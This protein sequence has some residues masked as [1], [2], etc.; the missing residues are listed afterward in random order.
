[1]RTGRL[2]RQITLQ[3]VSVVQ[4]DLGQPIETWTN[5]A[6]VWAERESQSAT[7]RFAAQQ[8]FAEVDIVWRIRWYPWAPDVRPDT[9]RVVYQGRPFNVLGAVELGRKEG[10]H[11]ATKARAE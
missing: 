11:I 6:T 5:V 4:D 9:H 10:L 3:S 1:V 8:R 2:D 7:K